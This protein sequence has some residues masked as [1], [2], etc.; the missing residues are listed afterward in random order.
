MISAAGEGL[1]SFQ[2]VQQRTLKRPVMMKMRMCTP[3][4]VAIAF[5]FES[6]RV[7]IQRPIC[8]EDAQLPSPLIG[9]ALIKRAT[10]EPKITFK[11]ELRFRTLS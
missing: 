11:K 2:V 7:G 5:S 10:D 4:P 8:L 9:K 3:K 6:P 1:F